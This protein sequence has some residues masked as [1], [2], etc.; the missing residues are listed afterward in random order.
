MTQRRLP[1]VDQA[2][3]ARLKAIIGRLEARLALAKSAHAEEVEQLR[4]EIKT[5]GLVLDRYA[6]RW[7]W[8]EE[9]VRRYVP[10]EQIE[11]FRAADV[12]HEAELRARLALDAALGVG[13]VRHD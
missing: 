9:V 2:E 7:R 12:A 4:A 11:A 13:G 1:H 5:A 3:I 6:A 10:T 8:V